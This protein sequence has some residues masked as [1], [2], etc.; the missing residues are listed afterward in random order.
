MREIGVLRDNINLGHM[1]AIQRSSGMD[2]KFY[3]MT[4]IS[5]DLGDVQ[6]ADL[7]QIG[8][9]ECKVLHLGKY[10]RQYQCHT[11][12]PVPG[13]RQFEIA[14]SLNHESARSLIGEDVFLIEKPNE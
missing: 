1:H 12:E 11:G 8:D 9:Q 4:F 3:S 10:L 5:H 14:T 7:L 13:G 2:S 6:V